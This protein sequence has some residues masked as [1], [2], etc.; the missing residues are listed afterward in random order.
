MKK[1][2]EKRENMSVINALLE[3]KEEQS[4]RMV[5][6]IKEIGDIFMELIDQ[7]KQKE[8]SLIELKS[9]IPFHVKYN[10]GIFLNDDN[11]LKKAFIIKVGKRR[12]ELIARLIQEEIDNNEKGTQH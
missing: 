1:E 7:Y 10:R 4:Y 5:D 12:S 9:Y 8:I 3:K 11:T 6:T 2:N